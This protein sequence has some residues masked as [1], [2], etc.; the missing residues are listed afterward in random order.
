MARA[1][2]KLL[3]IDDSEDDFLLTRRLLGCSKSVE[4]VL[5]WVQSARLGLEAIAA[6]RHDAYLVDY[7]LDGATGLELLRAAQERGCRAPIIILTAQGDAEVDR[8][9]M[10][11]GAADYLVK[12]NQD[13]E[14]L[15]RVICH[16]L[17]RQR[18]QTALAEERQ[19]LR[20]L[21]DHLPD[22]IYFKDREG[23]F[24][25]NNQAHLRVLGAVQ[26]AEVTGKRDSDFFPA[27]LAAKYWEDEQRVLSTGQPVLNTEERVIGASREPRWFLTSKVPLRTADGAITGIVGISRDI[28]TL[29]EAR[30][31]LRRAHDD[32]ER[33]VRERTAE[34]EQEI[35][36]R[37]RV[38][39]ELR[40]AL[41][42][43][44][45][46]D[47][48]KSE[49]VANVSHELKTPLTS[50]MYGTRNLLQGVA[51]P[52]PEG[53][54]RYLKMFDRECQRLVNTINNILD[55][56]RLE[57]GLGLTATVRLPLARV[58]HRGVE[59][60]RIQAEAA[61]VAVQLNLDWRA[62]FVACDPDMLE[63]VVHNV[64]GNAIKFTPAGGT[65]AVRVSREGAAGE[66]LR[67]EIEDTGIGIPAEA[68]GR[69]TERYFRVGG[70]PHGSGLG[71]ALAREAVQ[72]HHGTLAVTSPP[73]GHAVGTLVTVRLPAS[74]PALILTVEDEA[75]VRELLAEQ[76]GAYGYRVQHATAAREALAALATQ[77][78]DAMILDLVLRDMHGCDLIVQLKGQEEWRRLPVLVIT[79]ADVDQA[80]LDVLNRF[81]VPVLSKPWQEAELLDR[82]ESVLTGMRVL[83]KPKA[84]GGG[85]R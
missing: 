75:E 64:L 33:R 82:L 72:A 25:L 14:L 17:E 85:V 53:A 29:Q 23:R 27:E 4:F 5:D 61:G 68:L 7:R 83:R 3:L 15:E 55:L 35:L 51:G 77:L 24:L 76:L 36:E 21:I 9:A 39:E 48:E 40:T 52:L 50:L 67:L 38:E 79:G 31:A 71:L 22:C 6:G 45:K 66:W 20:T 10:S 12:D 37:R 26:Q 13:P 30:E 32:L 69:V 57:R 43:L 47:R 44:E 73:P 42:R 28:T 49:F 80:R 70:H 62:G 46:H 41:L 65:V 78:P 58:V 60:L 11:A 16:A 74:E 63:R 84:A 1:T 56:N 59:A 8:A 54:V 2:V 81:S 19:R 18:A 34:L